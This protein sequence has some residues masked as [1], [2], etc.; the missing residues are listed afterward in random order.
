MTFHDSHARPPLDREADMNSNIGLT[1]ADTSELDS[2]LTPSDTVVKISEVVVATLKNEEFIQSLAPLICKQVMELLKPD[3][4]KIVHEKVAPLEAQV[5]D[6][7][8]II[9]YQQNQIDELNTKVDNLENRVE[10]QEQYSRRTSLR[11]NNVPVPLD[12]KGEVIYPID[13]DK[14]VLDICHNQLKKKSIKIDDIGR[15]HPIGKMKDNKISII[16]RFLGY[17]KRQSVFSSKRL[18]KGNRH[19]IFITEN[20]TKHRYE[21]LSEIGDLYKAKKVH[22]YW[23]HDGTILVK[24]SKD[25]KGTIKIQS[26][27]DVRDKLL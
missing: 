22:A 23:T 5:F 21:L 8:K 14:L 26:R 11:F 25:E 1:K 17:Y 3:L 7:D 20:L 27:N 12:E 10:E 9:K 4:L 16:V 13:T 19:N 6:Q 18:L 24:R 15:T 2:I